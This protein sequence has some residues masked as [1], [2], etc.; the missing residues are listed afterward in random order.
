MCLTVG[1]L[2]GQRAANSGRWIGVSGRLALLAALKTVQL[3]V[4]LEV[5]RQ[6][7]E[8]LYGGDEVEEETMNCDVTAADAE[9]R[10]GCV[11]A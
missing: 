10:S 6:L 4:V 1:R 7:S 11:V 9:E 5:E 8:W 3:K 2:T